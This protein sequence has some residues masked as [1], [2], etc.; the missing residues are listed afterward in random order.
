MHNYHS[1]ATKLE[2]TQDVTVLSNFQINNQLYIIMH[3]QEE[4][5]SRQCREQVKT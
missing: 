1:A 2:P 5:Y 3:S 4:T